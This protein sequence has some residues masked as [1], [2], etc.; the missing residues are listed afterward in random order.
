[1]PGL[2][3]GVCGANGRRFLG[4]FKEYRQAFKT[5][6]LAYNYAKYIIEKSHS[7]DPIQNT[8]QPLKYHGSSKGTDIVRKSAKP[9]GP[10]F[11][12]WL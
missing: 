1:M 6:G 12:K 7:F 4:R 2:Q 10:N 3:Q 9:P 5:N 8:M 11:K